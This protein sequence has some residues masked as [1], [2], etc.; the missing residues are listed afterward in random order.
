MSEFMWRRKFVNEG[1]IGA[2]LTFC[3][4]VAQYHLDVVPMEEEN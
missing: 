4:H 2:F 1:N 3:E